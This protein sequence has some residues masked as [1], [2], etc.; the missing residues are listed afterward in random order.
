MRDKRI[1]V[2]G[3]RS[4]GSRAV[5]R[6]IRE[7]PGLTAPPQSREER[8]ARVAMR[9]RAKSL[10]R[11]LGSPWR[12]LY[13]DALKDEVARSAGPLSQWKHAAPVFD[14]VFVSSR[15]SVLFLVRDPYSWSLALYRN[16]HHYWGEPPST[17]AKFLRRPWLSL[18]RDAT[19][20]V[21]ASPV[22]LWNA[23][24]S[25]YQRFRA[26][27]A[28]YGVDTAVL[29]FE[30]FVADPK[31]AFLGALSAMDITGI[32]PVYDDAPTKAAG[33]SGADRRAYYQSEA[34]RRDLRPGDIELINAHLD[35]SLAA[36]FGY[37]QRDPADFAPPPK[38]PR[39]ERWRRR[40]G[41]A[42]GLN[43]GN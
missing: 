39:L 15:T 20:A 17:L 6:M 28:A 14:N 22:E 33:L 7:T 19:E 11:G 37:N 5:Q 3:E 25:A 41:R 12:S 30:A 43:R 8:A 16:A 1:K 23:K 31:A 4:T 21:L 9:A 13:R 35:W 32:D 27:A 10:T 34:W 36:E 38:P 40:L 26:E 29:T 18:G 24:V 2:F 42:M